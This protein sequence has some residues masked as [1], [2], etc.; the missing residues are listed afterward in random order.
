MERRRTPGL[1]REEVAARASMSV[2][3]YTRLEQARGAT[4][5]ARMLDALG[6]ALQL[7][8]ADRARLFALAGSAPTAPRRLTRQVSSQMAGL[9]ERM[10]LTAAI[11]TAASYEVIAANALAQS[12]LPGLALQANLAR[13]YFLQGRHWTSAA[14]DFAEVAVARLRSAATRYPADPELAALVA[15]LRAGSEAFRALWAADP[16]RMP[17]HRVKVVDHPVAGRLT[18]NCNV[19]LSPEDDQQ[20]V[21]ITAEPGTADEQAL[22]ALA[23]GLS[24]VAR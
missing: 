22:R 13:R 15:E 9:L 1:R 16:T 21:L 14:D 17:G 12:L 24:H 11:V 20:I 10:P 6:D 2:E 23:A 8:P 18:V 19:L 4:P 3:Y 7:N 5:S